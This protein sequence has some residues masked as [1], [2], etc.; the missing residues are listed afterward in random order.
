MRKVGGE[1]ALPGNV[2]RLRGGQ[3]GSNEKHH[4]TNGA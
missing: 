3:A 4:A 1:S 2:V